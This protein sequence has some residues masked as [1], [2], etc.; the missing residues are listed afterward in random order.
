MAM[1][2]AF[3]RRFKGSALI[4]LPV[5]MASIGIAAVEAAD[6]AAPPQARKIEAPGPEWDDARTRLAQ[7]AI[8]QRVIIRVPMMRR[9]LPP[10]PGHTDDERVMAK[11]R[12]PPVEWVE[13]SGPK[14]IKVA[15][16]RAAAITSSRGIDL[17]LENNDRLRALLDRECGTED[18]Y[19]GFYIQ[20][21][22]DGALCAGRDRVLARS[23]ADC[24]ISGLKRLKPGN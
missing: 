11:R 22:E 24:G 17:V 21:S 7:V 18:L 12:A 16:L 4:L 10:P 23:G 19:S 15:E 5:I 6:K 14:C 8:E 13:H 2:A 9:P 3:I 20:P 1:Q